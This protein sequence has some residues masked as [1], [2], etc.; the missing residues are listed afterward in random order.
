ME[1]DKLK[2][3]FGTCAGKTSFWNEEE[4]YLAVYES[5]FRRE[6]KMKKER[7]RERARAREKG[8]TQRQAKSKK[9]KESKGSVYNNNASCPEIVY[10]HFSS[11]GFC[12]Q[13]RGHT[14]SS[15]PS[16]SI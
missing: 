12:S 9:E 4:K 5:I 6:R 2:A 8:R 14:N 15:S 1:E 11:F 16:P 10:F 3:L 7:E 13:K